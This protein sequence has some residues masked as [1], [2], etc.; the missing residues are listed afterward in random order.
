MSHQK[1]LFKDQHGWFL[2]HQ[3]LPMLEPCDIKNR[4][5]GEKRVPMLRAQS[6]TCKVWLT[7]HKDWSSTRLRQ[8]EQASSHIVGESERGRRMLGIIYTEGSW[9]STQPL[10]PL[11]K[12]GSWFLQLENS[13][14]LEREWSVRNY[15]TLGNRFQTEFLYQHSRLLS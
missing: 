12:T 7:V 13:C 10:S 5:S 2:W 6:W 11:D 8:A 15:R 9:L 4:F 3:D 14:G 1:P